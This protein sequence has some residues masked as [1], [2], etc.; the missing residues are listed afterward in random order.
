MRL[1]A[2]WR[3]PTINGV[4]CEVNLSDCMSPV[5]ELHLGLASHVRIRLFE[6]NEIGGFCTV[7]IIAGQNESTD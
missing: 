1:A 6:F 4:H 3:Q 7:R 5:A 2:A